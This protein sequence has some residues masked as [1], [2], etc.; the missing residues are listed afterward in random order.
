MY[1][2][3]TY[4]NCLGETYKNCLGEVIW[5]NTHNIRSLDNK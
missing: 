4:K 3:D 5:I 1:A 2:V